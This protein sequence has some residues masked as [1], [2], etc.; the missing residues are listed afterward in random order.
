MIMPLYFLPLGTDFDTN[1]ILIKVYLGDWSIPFYTTNNG[2]CDIHMLGRFSLIKTRMH[3][4]YYL[5]SNIHFCSIL[6]F[7]NLL[8]LLL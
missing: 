3:I 1:M 4:R 7:P 8:C 2:P 5:M 6:P